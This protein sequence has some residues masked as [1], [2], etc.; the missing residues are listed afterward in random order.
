MA[1]GSLAVVLAFGVALAQV[2]DPDDVKRRAL[3]L[4]QVQ[5]WLAGVAPRR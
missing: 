4:A 3:V 2:S 5:N 1:P